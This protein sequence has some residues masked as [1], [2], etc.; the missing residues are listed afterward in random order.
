MHK[1]NKYKKFNDNEFGEFY[2]RF[3]KKIKRMTIS[4]NL[5]GDLMVVVPIYNTLEDVFEFIYSKN[6]WIKENKNKIITKNIRVINFDFDSDLLNTFKLKIKLKVDQISMENNFNYSKIHFKNMI[7][8][9]GSC[10]SKNNISF[11]TL[12]YHLEDDLQDYIIK[13]EL[14]HTKIKNHSKE[15]WNALEEICENSKQKNTTIN[16][17]YFIKYY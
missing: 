11:N 2:L 3:S 8:R 1:N 10:S 6:K 9:W 5:I 14:L 13:H 15:F 16:R 7:S 4:I 17:S 12:M